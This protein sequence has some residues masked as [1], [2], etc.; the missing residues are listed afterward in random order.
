M[1]KKILC[2]I[3]ATMLMLSSF[4]Y[5]SPDTE[6]IAALGGYAP[7]DEK[8]VTRG[9]F[10][11]MAAG[12]FANGISLEKTKTSFKDV[13]SSNQY[14]GAVK[15]ASDLGWV[16]GYGDGTFGVNDNITY[17]QSIIV[18]L[19][20]LGYEELI[21]VF[22]S[23]L[24]A[25]NYIGLTNNVETES[26]FLTGNGAAVLLK[27]AL[28]SATLVQTGF[29][30][31]MNFEADPDV[32]NLYTFLG[33]EAVEGIVTD[34]G[35]TSLSARSSVNE[36]YMKIGGTLVFAGDIAVDEY[37]GYMVKAYI[38]TKD[39]KTPELVYIDNCD[40]AVVKIHADSIIDAADFRVTYEDSY[41]K[42][43]TSAV[44]NTADYIYNGVADPDA[45]T[46]DLKITDGAV[47]LIDNDTDGKADVVRIEKADIAVVQDVSFDASYISVH[48]GSDI[49]VPDDTCFTVIKDGKVTDPDKLEEWNVLTVYKSKDSAVIT[50]YVS[51]KIFR[52][53]LTEKS[54]DRETLTIDGEKYILANDALYDSL[55]PGIE[56]EFCADMYGNI[57]YTLDSFEYTVAVYMD[58]KSHASSALGND[59]YVKVF[60]QEGE[61]KE[62]ICAENVRFGG[63]TVS[64]S[65]IPGLVSGVGSYGLIGYNLNREGKISAMAV[66]S[67]ATPAG[68]TPADNFKKIGENTEI[69]YQDQ[70]K[71]FAGKVMTNNATVV[72]MLPVNPLDEDKY[73][74]SQVSSFVSG[75]EYDIVSYLAGNDDWY[76]DYIVCKE[77]NVFS[78][79][80]GAILVDRIT[81]GLDENGEETQILYGYNEK[82]EVVYTAAKDFS[83]T[84][85]SLE[86]GDIVRCIL[87]PFGK[88]CDTRKVFSGNDFVF[89]SEADKNGTYTA[90]PRFIYGYVYEKNKNLVK[91]SIAPYE[92]PVISDTSMEIHD[93]SGMKVYEYDSTRDTLTVINTDMLE[94]YMT[95]PQEY[96]KIFY[97]SLNSS[98][99][100]AVSYK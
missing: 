48:Y 8:L 50:V 10:V 5:A 85:H 61:I 28:E 49:T 27:N 69:V 32:K 42:E 87:N 76:A 95:Y 11:H 67:G 84:S 31:E 1:I 44:S 47:V 33:I 14:S 24:S 72:F 38:K 17:E 71:S 63:K 55:M 94:D 83:F 56:Y 88:V 16:S 25:A 98:P 74:V 90:Q 78:K 58:A 13:T 65:D 23:Y 4:A 54:S 73:F 6:L 62:L 52:G 40:T 75:L 2:F 19:R 66:P 97:Y 30:D 82:G 35:I 37:I 53:T 92:P 80:N 22:G 59:V 46:S 45:V 34:N 3:I 68:Y 81:N 29:G 96:S 21:S 36:G 70:Q 93:F 57:V 86:R 43:K 15:A 60:T 20:A 51:D 64:D 77:Q 91:I 12:L 41:G 79:T 39:V 26:S 9:E 89:V 100:F 18:T 99:K 7:D